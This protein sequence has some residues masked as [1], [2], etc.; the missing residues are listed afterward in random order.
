MRGTAQRKHHVY[1]SM[2]L[3]DICAHECVM[4]RECCAE[5]LDRC[6]FESQHKR[7][8]SSMNA[9]FMKR[10]TW[11]WYALKMPCRISR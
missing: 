6:T 8:E 7:G 2:L 11:M 9:A 4:V 5:S 10:A 3:Y 1:S